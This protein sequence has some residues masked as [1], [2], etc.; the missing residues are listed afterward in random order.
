M[1]GCTSK[2]ESQEHVNFAA[3]EP[4][5]SLESNIP[6]AN[7]KSNLDSAK[8]KSKLDL[9]EQQLYLEGNSVNYISQL[10]SE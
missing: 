7:V 10:A 1:G 2:P 4:N 9:P 3:T 5:Q 8:V 6:G